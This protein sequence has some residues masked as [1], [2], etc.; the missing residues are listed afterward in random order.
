M[1]I[2]IEND[3]FVRI[4]CIGLLNADDTLKEF[5]PL[6]VKVHGEMSLAQQQHICEISQV[7][8]RQ[9][10][11]QLAEYFEK[12]KKEQNENEQEKSTYNDKSN[13]SG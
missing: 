6:Y 8:I 3:C 11:K 12:L 4:A 1:S 9:H 10:E 5:V 7:I 2:G 13:L